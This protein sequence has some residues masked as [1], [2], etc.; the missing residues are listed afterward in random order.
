MNRAG[1]ITHY[2]T[3]DIQTGGVQKTIQFL[4]TNIGNE[5][6]IL[7]YPWMAAFKPKF[8]WKNGVIN[9]KELPIILQSVNPFIPGKDPIIARIEGTKSNSQLRATT[10][11]KLAIKVQ[12]YTKKVEVPTEYQQFNKV[13][14]KQESKQFPPKRAWDHAIEFKKGCTRSN[15]L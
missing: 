8:I 3:L 15:Q 10:S 1:E 12:Q 6:I 2:I 14:S 11:T 7:G 5:D 4:V 9:E 13:F